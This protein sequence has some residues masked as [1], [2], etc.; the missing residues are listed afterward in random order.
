MLINPWK[1]LK[2]QTEIKL[3]DFNLCPLSGLICKQFHW[4]T[5]AEFTRNLQS[6]MER[7]KSLSLLMKCRFHYINVK[8][9][10]IGAF[11]KSK[12]LCCFIFE[13]TCNT[14]HNSS[15]TAT[16]NHREFKKC[17]PLSHVHTAKEVF[18]KAIFSRCLH[19]S[20]V[21]TRYFWALL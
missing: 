7:K 1:Q 11:L 5:E 9:S 15:V 18:T 19:S 14:S 4:L 6:C 16:T 8:N 21:P 13:I 2:R 3:E 12:E 10:K 17:P 20:D